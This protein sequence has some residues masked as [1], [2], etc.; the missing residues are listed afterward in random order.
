MHFVYFLRSERNPRK[1]YTGYTNDLDRRLAEHN[2][3]DNDGYT[4]G[5]QPW[6]IEAYVSCDTEQTAVIVEAYFKN[7]SG[8]EKFSN[9]EE[10]NPNHPNPKQGFFDTLEVG[11]A[12]GSGANR[13]YVHK[14]RGRTIMKMARPEV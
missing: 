5:F 11:R 8:K 12:F 7:T 9:F 14:E 1:T 2:H 3:P 10:A 4:G 6:R 13:F